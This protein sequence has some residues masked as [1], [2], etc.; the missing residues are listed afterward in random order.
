[1]RNRVDETDIDEVYLEDE[2]LIAPPAPTPPTPPAAPARTGTVSLNVVESPPPAAPVS[3]VVAAPPISS[4]QEVA[5]TN[6][7]S[8][9]AASGAN[10]DEPRRDEP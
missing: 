1:M 9:S 6:S 3:P 5:P 2:V 8:P 7:D 10:P 4:I